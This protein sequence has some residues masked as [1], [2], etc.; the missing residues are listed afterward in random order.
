MILVDQAIWLHND[1]KWAHLVS[2]TS[3]EELHSFAASLG[4]ER[5]AFQEDH[6]DVPSDVRDVAISLG[7]KAVDFRELARSLKRSG[8]RRSHR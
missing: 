7:A 8:L 6:Y 3:Y 1:K 5:R 4:I 2:D